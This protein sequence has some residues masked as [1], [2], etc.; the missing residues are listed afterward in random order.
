MALQ[1][2]ISTNI[3]LKLSSEGEVNSPLQSKLERG[4]SL[5][6]GLGQ[7]VVMKVK[8][9]PFSSIRI[10]CLQGETNQTGSIYTEAT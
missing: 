8:S 6:S 7:K 1:N 10:G 3:E 2:K 9:G 4:N 5:I